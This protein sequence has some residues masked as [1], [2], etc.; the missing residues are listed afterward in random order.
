M[1]KT[2][3]LSFGEKLGF[4]LGDTAS[5]LFWQTFA[6]FLMY[7][8]TDVFGITA[9]AA[10]T[11]FLVVRFFDFANDP[12]MGVIADRTQT[13]WGK[14]RPYL[15]YLAI[16]FAVL[17]FLTFSTPDFSDSGK[18]IYAYVTYTLM[19]VVYTAINI[20][21]SALMGV[22]SADPLERTKVSSYR[23]VAAFAGGLIV[24][25]TALKLV[26]VLGGDSESL[27]W[28][29]T[30]AVFAFLAA[31]LF[32]T[33]FFTTRERVSPPKEQKTSLRED[34][35]NLLANI[36]WWILVAVGIF[37]LTFVTIRN[38]S[39]IYYFKNFVGEQTIR[40]FGREFDLTT[41]SLTS[42]FMVLG[43]GSNI[44]GVMLTGWLSKLFGKKHSFIGLILITIVL[45]AM[46][47]FLNPEQVLIMFGLQVIISLVMGPMSP[48]LWSMYTDIADYSEWKNGRRATGLVMSASTMAQKFG[49]T[50]GGAVLGWLLGSFGYN[51]D[52]DV[53]APETI[54]GIRLLI[55]VIPAIMAVLTFA[56]MAFYKLDEKTVNMI[57]EEL[58]KRRDGE[59]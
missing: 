56:G 27:G 12:I 52:L 25:A 10:G 33:T 45:S 14:F 20:P 37:L 58:E 13:R 29:L 43:T 21:Y 32:I 48:I 17:G 6:M 3:K 16:P 4:S 35:K 38:G 2:S 19:M 24:Q 8:Y 49:W 23:F 50:I 18:L 53:Q 55:S 44:L 15:L 28:Q 39:I 54:R 47:I 11:M 42:I 7:F 41:D 30:M 9:A 40:L 22:I 59:G 26:D 31:V 5:N 57:K 46:F 51:G 34:L 1:N 36:P